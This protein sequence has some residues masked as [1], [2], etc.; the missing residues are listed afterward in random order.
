MFFLYGEAKQ[1]GTYR[2]ERGMTVQQAIAAGGGI[3]P[4]GSINRLRITRG[5][6]TAAR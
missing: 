2:I 5:R 4:R 3:T 1:P 6:P